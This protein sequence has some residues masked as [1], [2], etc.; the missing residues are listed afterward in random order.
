MA[1]SPVKESIKFELGKRYLVELNLDIVLSNKIIGLLDTGS[2]FS[3]IKK[4]CLKKNTNIMS[5]FSTVITGINNKS[6]KTLG[7]VL[8]TI[9]LG[10]QLIVK[11]FQIIPDNILLQFDA[12]IGMNILKDC[13]I[14]NSINSL[15]FSKLGCELP[16]LENIK[17]EGNKNN[18]TCFIEPR[19]EKL[20]RVKTDLPDGEFYLQASEIAENVFVPHSIIK[21]ENSV[22]LI[23]A[24]NISE[25]TVELGKL[26]KLKTENIS[27]FNLVALTENENNVRNRK[28]EEII[29]TSHMNSEERDSILKIC[30]QYN[31][32]FHLEGDRLTHT[33]AVQH[34]INLKNDKP[35]SQKPYRV[36]FGIVDE[37]NKQIEDLLDNGIIQPSISAYS[38]PSFLIPKK[39]KDGKKK[40]RLVIDYRKLNEVTEDDC[41]PLPNLNDILSNLGKAKYF[42]SLDLYSGYHQIPVNPVDRHKT[43]FSTPT[44]HYEFLRL[45]FGLKTAPATFQRLMN[46]VMSGLTGFKSYVYM[47]DLVLLDINL[48]LHNIKLKQIFDRLSS[49]NLKLQ[50]EK[51]QFLRKEMGFLGH[52][53]RQDGLQPEE[54]KVK[55]VQDFPRPKNTKQIKSFLGLAGYY[56]K[57]IKD[58]ATISE[59]LVKLLRK[60]LKYKWT[61]ACEQSFIELKRI[62]TTYPILIHPN[63]NE[64]FIIIC[65]ASTSGLG[66]VLAQIRNNEELPVA[67]ASRVLNRAERNY[68]TYE[69]E[70]LGIVWSVTNAFRPF[71]YGQKFIINTDH[72]AL[73]TIFNSNLGFANARITRWKLKLSEYNFKIVYR[74]GKAI[75]NADALSRIQESDASVVILEEQEKYPKI[76]VIEVNNFHNTVDEETLQETLEDKESDIAILQSKEIKEIPIRKLVIEDLNRN[77]VGVVTRKQAAKSVE[78]YSEK[79]REFEEEISVPNNEFD[80]SKVSE[81]S[82]NEKDLENKKFVVYF[83]SKDLRLVKPHLSDEVKRLKL[84]VK[85]IELINNK[86]FVV[87]KDKFNEKV[88]KLEIFILMYKLKKFCE[89]NSIDTLYINDFEEFSIPYFM[90]KM[91]LCFTFKQS[92]VNIFLIRKM[93]QKIDNLQIRKEIIENYHNSLVGGHSGIT[94]TIKRIKSHYTWP[95]IKREVTDFIKN[96]HKCQINKFQKKTKIPLK[97]TTT[98]ERAFQRISL[99]MVGPINTSNNNTY[100]LTMIDDLTKYLIAVPIP[101]GEANTIAE[102]FVKNFILIY[103][104]PETILTDRG[105]NFMS[106]V[107]R[108]VCKLFKIK[109]FC[110]SSYHPETNGNVERVHRTLKD[111][112]R[113]FVDKSLQNWDELLPFAIF[114]YN[115]SVHSSTGFSPYE[116]IFGKEASIPIKVSTNTNLPVYNYDDYYCYIK[117]V[118]HNMQNMAKSCLEKAKE[119]N[120]KYYDRNAKGLEIEEGDLILLENIRK[121]HGQKLQPLRQ[122]PYEVIEVLSDE[123]VKIMI[124]GKPRIVH[125]NR[126]FPYHQDILVLFSK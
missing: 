97:I 103:G 70:L 104:Q 121:G 11:E 90:L 80:D 17:D 101:N 21:S 23:S 49:Y 59:P 67:Y 54:A 123:N 39:S 50:P 13:D 33:D 126:L 106:E 118:L 56:R 47:D 10:R 124:N 5:D 41:F 22:A 111:Y 86:I 68:S 61:E 88:E 51:C 77:L 40:Y 92:T 105:S 34:N 89:D 96:C 108:N 32:I 7:T 95:T 78:N 1:G 8:G 120:K 82:E 24:I 94:R 99:D 37:Y 85:D 35:I 74:P 93:I 18:V 19:V 48:E 84:Q 87:Y 38:A 125:K 73:I 72:K 16:L 83:I 15:K 75:L 100:I 107:F 29:D 6:T 109:K 57:F 79:L 71:V 63:F 45:S 26:N 46:T 44:G 66:G 65:D 12:L 64:T 117:S 55:A 3:F 36:P 114:C 116:L 122:G 43:A 58:F 31:H 30:F 76:K 113:N 20:I 98:S 119:K 4:K 69:R 102:A 112:L 9:K 81:I 2:T 115:T 60:D 28:L 52:F 27:N 42:T 91:M 53:V 62:L 14:L 110:C 25:E